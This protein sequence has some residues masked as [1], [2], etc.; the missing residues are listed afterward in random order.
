[1]D[2]PW[3]TRAV[4]Q[5]PHR[6]P[7][8]LRLITRRMSGSWPFP[9]NYTQSGLRE[10][11]LVG[12]LG[13]GETNDVHKS[14]GA[15]SGVCTDAGLPGPRDRDST[16]PRIA[17]LHLPLNRQPTERTARGMTR[18]LLFPQRNT[19]K[20]RKV[21][22]AKMAAEVRTR[23]LCMCRW[24]AIRRE[25]KLHVLCALLLLLVQPV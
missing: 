23:C 24:T 15:E 21:T 9:R 11:Q 17:V 3:L 1:M 20:A 14:G 4:S 6:R 19:P 12:S 22:S 7:F 5:S 25:H 13:D 8:S 2:A 16:V 10:P 18:G